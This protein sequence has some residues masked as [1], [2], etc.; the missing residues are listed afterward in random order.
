MA[1]GRLGS[2]LLE[3]KCDLELYGLLKE[4]LSKGFEHPEVSYYMGISCW[5]LGNKNEAIV[6]L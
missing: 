4:L 6:Y 5:G 1:V 2:L 3:Q